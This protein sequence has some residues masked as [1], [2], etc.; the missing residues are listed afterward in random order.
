MSRQPPNNN[1]TDSFD[2][3]LQAIEQAMNNMMQGAFGMLFKEFM[4]SSSGGSIFDQPPGGMTTT[5]IF[6]GRNINQRRGGVVEEVI[7]DDELG[8]NDFKRL[9]NKR[10]QNRLHGG[11][12][13]S[14]TSSGVVV[15]E[16]QST[17]ASKIV[18]NNNITSK[19]EIM[20]DF[21]KTA[22]AAAGSIFNLLFHNTADVLFNREYPPSSVN[23]DLVIQTPNNEVGCI[24]SEF[25]R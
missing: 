9:A 21:D 3:D 22:S 24:I 13:K 15:E 14:S 18:R 10:K 25:F 20:S 11:D 5:T 12:E 19:N 8:G 17:P 6:D 2:N 4:G 7:E 23:Q 16:S 1:N